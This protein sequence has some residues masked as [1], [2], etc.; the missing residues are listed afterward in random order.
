MTDLNTKFSGNDASCHL[1]GDIARSETLEDRLSRRFKFEQLLTDLFSSFINIEYSEINEKIE[2][3]LKC[4]GEHLDMD[5]CHLAQYD[6]KRNFYPITHSW[7]REGI[8]PIPVG[9]NNKD[10]PWIADQLLGERTVRIN[11][12]G[13]LP[14]ECDKER[15]IL[16]KLKI[17]SHL[18]L[19]Q[20]DNGKVWGCLSL[21]YVAQEIHW[22]EH[23]VMRLRIVADVLLNL[24]IKRRSDEKLV[25]ALDEIRQLKEKLENER[26]CL[27]EEIQRAH[28]FENIIGNSESLQNALRKAERVASTDTTVLIQG[29]TGTGKE[30]FARAIHKKSRRKNEPLIKLNCASLPSN[31]IESELFGHE[32]GAFTGAH[33]DRKGRFEIADGATIFLDEIGELP[34]ETQGKLLTVLE[35]GEFERLGSSHTKKVDVRIVA[36]TNRNLEN[37]VREGRFRKDLWYR[38]NV[39]TIVVPPLRERE[40]DVPL[41]VNWMLER[42]C[43]QLGKS[44][45]RVS[46]GTMKSLENYAWPGNIR[47]LQNVIE[48]AVINSEGNELRLSDTLRTSVAVKNLSDN[49]KTIYDMEH[50]YILQ[51]L[52]KTRWQVEGGGGASEILGLP[53]STLRARMKKYGIRRPMYFTIKS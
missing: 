37:E 4:I 46:A 8:E 39:F 17:M 6:E 14:A 53:P 9:F 16:L 21:D 35:Y 22:D 36:A 51:V 25:G 49:F 44:I 33:I 50:D 41:L 45:D 27:R 20:I 18:S 34:L 48:R 52:K 15:E 23:L 42:M 26:N 10:V 30:L 1:S 31:L 11:S 5:R 38:L 40:D 12:H 32:K 13:D 28:D 47:E 2:H 24:L 19:P 43:K 29:E 3:A 7:T